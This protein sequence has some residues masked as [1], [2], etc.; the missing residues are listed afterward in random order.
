MAGC[1]MS[2]QLFWHLPI[3]FG[4]SGFIATTQGFFLIELVSHWGLFPLFFQ[5]ARPDRLKGIRPI[6]LRTRGFM[7]AVSASICPIGSLLLLFVPP[8]PRAKHPAFSSFFAV[9]IA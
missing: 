4:I 9:I 8:S 6:S 5:D 7:W 2:A 1:V 3:S